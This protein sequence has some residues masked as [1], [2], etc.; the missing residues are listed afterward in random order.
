[1][2][3][4]QKGKSMKRKRSWHRLRNQDAKWARAVRRLDQATKTTTSTSSRTDL[5]TRENR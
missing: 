3:R 1:M 4:R 5:D 2:G